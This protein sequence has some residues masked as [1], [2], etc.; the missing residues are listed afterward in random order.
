[1]REAYLETRLV[2]RLATE[3]EAEAAKRVRT[4]KL[5]SKPTLPRVRR[6]DRE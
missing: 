1:M 5:A 3:I 4:A 6:G 2:E